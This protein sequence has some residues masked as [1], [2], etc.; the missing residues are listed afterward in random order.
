MFVLC[1]LVSAKPATHAQKT[2]YVGLCQ[3]ICKATRL[4]YK[5]SASEHDPR[6]QATAAQAPQASIGALL[7][8][9]KKRDIKLQC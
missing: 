1:R 6:H 4:I 3:N 9:C 8:C 2:C 7:R 5:Q